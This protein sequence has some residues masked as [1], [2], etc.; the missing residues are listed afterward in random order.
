MF[1]TAD[2]A[3][4]MIVLKDLEEQVNCLDASVFRLLDKRRF[5]VVSVSGG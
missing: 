4:T 2:Q 1:V 5:T 3:K